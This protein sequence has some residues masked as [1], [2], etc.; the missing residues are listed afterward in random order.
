MP[1]KFPGLNELLAAA[2]MRR[3]R[4]YA[5]IKRRWTHQ[6]AE[7]ARA[8]R[9]PQYER[10]R[11]AFLWREGSR[12]RDP[13]NVAAGGRKLIL[14]GL[15]EAGVLPNDGWGNVV[16]W[17]DAW[18]VCRTPGVLVTIETAD[19]PGPPPPASKRT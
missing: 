11:F 4:V 3:G 12:R 14:D 2:K 1:G 7:A 15:V 17:T 10:A 8:Q 19:D 16:G 18:E 5:A 9:I 6:V 13:D